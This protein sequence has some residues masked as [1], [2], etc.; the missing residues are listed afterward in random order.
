MTAPFVEHPST[1]LDASVSALALNP[2]SLQG[3][4]LALLGHGAM[5]D[6]SLLGGVKQTQC[7]RSEYFGFWP[8][9]DYA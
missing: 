6:L 2:P 7:A 3:R 4:L 8:E 9:V 1:V 5:R